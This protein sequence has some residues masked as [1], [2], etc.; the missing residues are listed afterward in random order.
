M[1]TVERITATSTAT[2]GSPRRRPR[3]T[4]W[5]TT[6][7]RAPGSCP[8]PR[9]TGTGALDNL[10]PAQ[11]R[12]VLPSFVER[13]SY[14]VKEPNPT[15]GIYGQVSDLEIQAAEISRMRR[16]LV[17]TLA[18]HSGR[19]PEQVRLDIERDKILTA[20]EAK[21]YGIID[22]IIQR[23]RTA[24]RARSPALVTPS[25]HGVLGCSYG[26]PRQGVPRRPWRARIRLN[27]G[28]DGTA[29]GQLGVIAARVKAAAAVSADRV[30]VWFQRVQ[31]RM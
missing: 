10:P 2:G 31:R 26:C 23:P 28:A 20:P 1:Q 13:T 21:E 29:C 27:Y 14:G 9:R 25:R 11:S 24:R 5:W 30:R 19:T 12:Y 22:E 16:L 8:T 4:A 15:E 17:A 6:W 7:S 3:S 18:K